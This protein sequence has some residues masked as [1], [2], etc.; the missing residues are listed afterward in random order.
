MF[1]LKCVKLWNNKHDPKDV[2][3]ELKKSLK[4]LGL[5]YLDLYLIHWP[6]ATIVNTIY[7]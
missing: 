3:G 2:E 4:S 7:I 6:F 1:E 5:K